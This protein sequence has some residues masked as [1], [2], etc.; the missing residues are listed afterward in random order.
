MGEITLNRPLQVKPETAIR[1]DFVDVINS[2][3]LLINSENASLPV[4]GVN[5]IHDIQSI[6]NNLNSSKESP[7]NFLMRANELYKVSKLTDEIIEAYGDFFTKSEYQKLKEISSNSFSNAQLTQGL[8]ILYDKKHPE[9]Y[10]DLLGDISLGANLVSKGLRNYPL[11]AE[12]YEGLKEL[13][14]GLLRITEQIEKDLDQE[15]QKSEQEVEPNIEGCQ[16]LKEY[17]YLNAV[18][19]LWLVEQ[20]EKTV[21]TKKET[22]RPTI[23]NILKFLK[24][25]EGGWAGDDLEECLEFVNEIR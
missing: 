20:F 11:N 5:K 10:L 14:E 18:S 16:V 2:L 3:E 9:K 19:I 15:S 21:D 13:G 25:S 24:T 22:N 4:D 23:K 7:M 6:L 8:Y 1:E 17:I 12:N